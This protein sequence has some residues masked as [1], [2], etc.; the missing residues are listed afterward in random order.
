MTKEIAF[1]IWLTEQETDH[2]VSGD[3]NAGSTVSWV[4]EKFAE[5]YGINK[6]LSEHD[7]ENKQPVK[8]R[9]NHIASHNG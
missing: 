8:E 5:F 7:I 1:Y 2:A 3:F 6:E 4:K 9:L